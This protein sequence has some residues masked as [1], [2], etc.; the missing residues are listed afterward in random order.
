M[1][2][3]EYIN[4]RISVGDE[5]IKINDK[6]HYIVATEENIHRVIPDGDRIRENLNQLLKQEH[7]KTIQVDY[8]L[9]KVKKDL[10]GVS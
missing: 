7:S 8:A 9:K 2:L 6:G 4:E 3:V 5:P 10:Y 1:T